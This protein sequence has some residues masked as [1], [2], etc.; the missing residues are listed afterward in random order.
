MAFTYDE[1]GQ[2][3]PLKKEKYEAPSQRENFR[4]VY[5]KEN[6]GADTLTKKV[7]FPLWLVCLVIV[8]IVIASI[9]VGVWAWKDW[10]AGKVERM[11]MRGSSVKQGFG[12]KFY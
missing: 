4:E 1:N 12:F 5:V 6:F 8:L 7:E 11:G 10:K 2:K 3:K 9:A